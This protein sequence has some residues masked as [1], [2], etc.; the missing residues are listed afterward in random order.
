MQNNLKIYIELD[1][2]INKIDIAE[3]EIRSV[4]LFFFENTHKSI[5]KR[6]ES[7]NKASCITII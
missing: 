2:Y 5:I 4:A 3:N 7:K 1:Q 6:L